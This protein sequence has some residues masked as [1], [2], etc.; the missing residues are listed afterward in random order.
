ML[1]IGLG[2]DLSKRLRVVAVHRRDVFVQQRAPDRFRPR[3]FAITG[4]DCG[5]TWNTYCSCTK[6][7]ENHHI[8]PRCHITPPC[9]ELNHLSRALHTY[10]VKL[11]IELLW[12]K[13]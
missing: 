5:R 1:D 4:R 10:I 9:E 2:R 3:G 13:R 8:P 12:V 11:G 7:S 6:E